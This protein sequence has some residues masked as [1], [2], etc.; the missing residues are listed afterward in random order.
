M[1]GLPQTGERRRFYRKAPRRE[2]SALPQRR[3]PFSKGVLGLAGGNAPCCVP[4]MAALGHS[5][6]PRA[7]VRQLNSK[8]RTT[9]LCAQSLGA[10]GRNRT[11]TC[12]NGILS[13][14][15][16]P[17]PPRPHARSILPIGPISGSIDRNRTDAFVSRICRARDFLPPSSIEVP[18]Q[19]CGDA[20][21]SG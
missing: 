2:K 4:S 12:G 17:V 14:A 3:S 9:S 15:R 7:R 13:A 6:R 10:G 11:D 5:R 8:S 1:A 21:P 20:K 16:L 18:S 19:I